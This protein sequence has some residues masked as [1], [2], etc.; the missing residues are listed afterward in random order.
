MPTTLPVPI[1]PTVLSWARNES[2]YPVESIAER[3]SVKPE[4]VQP[5]E[6]G[7]LPPT[8]RQVQELAKFLHRPLNLFFSQ[9]PPQV[10]PLATEYRRLPGVTLPHLST[11]LKT[12][13][14]HALFLRLSFLV[15]DNE[16]KT[17]KLL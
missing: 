16:N 17:N 5:W 7:D 13:W 1:N 12:I 15:S 9:K 6:S 11:N 14:K 3:L 10:S 8:L 2:G 4:R